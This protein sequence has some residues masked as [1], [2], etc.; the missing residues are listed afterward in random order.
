MHSTNGLTVSFVAPNAGAGFIQE[1]DFADGTVM[2]ATNPTHTY[3]AEGTYFVR[4]ITRDI[5]MT[6]ADTVSQ[7]IVVTA[8]PSCD[9]AFT[10]NTNN[11][12]VDFTASNVQPSDNLMWDFGDGNTSTVAN[13]SHTY[14][15]AGTYTV[16]LVVQDAAFTCYDS[17]A[18]TL[19]LSAPSA[20]CDA[21]FNGPTSGTTGMSMTFTA[22]NTQPTNGFEW[23]INGMTIPGATGPSLTFSPTST[24]NLMLVVSDMGCTDTTMQTITITSPPTCD[25]AFTQNTNNLTV[26][27]TASN[28]QPSDNLMWDFGDGNTSTVVNPSH[29]YA[30]A[31]TYTVLLVVQDAAFTCYDSTAQTLTVSAPSAT[32]D[33]SF[34]SANNGLTFSA[35]PNNTPAGSTYLWDFGDGNTSTQVNP[36]HNYTAQ[37]TYTVTLIHQLGACS[38][39]STTMVGMWAPPSNCNAGITASVNGMTVSFAMINPG[40]GQSNYW[41]FGDGNSSV[42]TNPTHT[43]AAPSNYMV[44]VGVSTQ[45]P[46]PFCTDSGFYVV[47]IPPPPATCDASFNQSV[48]GDTVFVSATNLNSNNTLL[49]QFGDGNSATNA[50]ANNVYAAPGTYTVSLIVQDIGMTCYDSTAQTIVISPPSTTCDASFTVNVFGDSINATANNPQPTDEYMWFVD[51]S[52]YSFQTTA[53]FDSSSLAPG[54]YTMELIVQDSNAT[55]SDTVSQTFTIAPLLAT[56]DASFNF[57]PTNLSVDFTST[58]AGS[59]YTTSWEFGDGNTSSATSPSHTYTSAG[60]YTVQLIVQDTGMTCADTIMQAVTVSAPNI[61]AC[62]VDIVPNSINGMSIDLSYTAD[63][64]PTSFTWEMGDGMIYSSPTAT[65]TYSQIGGYLIQLVAAD[66]LCADTAYYSAF[67]TPN[68]IPNSCGASFSHTVASDGLTVIF[69]DHSYDSYT[70]PGTNPNFSALETDNQAIPFAGTSILTYTYSAAGTYQAC[71]AVYDVGTGCSD[72][73]CKQITVN[74][75]PQTQTWNINGSVSTFQ[76]GTMVTVSNATVYLVEFDNSVV[77]TLTAADSVVLSPSDSGQYVFNNL[78]GGPYYVKAALNTT[79]PN[80]NSFVPTYYGNTP[81]WIYAS[82][83]PMAQLGQTAP[84]VLIAG[85]NPGGP[86]FIG[87]SLSSGANKITNTDVELSDVAVMLF[88]VSDNSLVDFDYSN[89]NDEFAIGN[90]PYGTYRLHGEVLGLKTFNHLITL[91]P[92][93]P[94]VDDVVIRVNESISTSVDEPLTYTSLLLYPNPAQDVA[95]LQVQLERPTAL[96]L[97]AFDIQG[98]QVLSQQADYAA[99]EAIISV[100]TADLADGLYTLQVRI[101]EQVEHFKLVVQR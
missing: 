81:Q 84:V 56:C 35:A 85:N 4:L 80:F 37:G 70:N 61:G 7:W 73:L 64:T 96:S 54:T 63:F 30:T 36:A 33:A 67:M 41:D 18:Q 91:G 31:G 25:A 44:Y 93:Q 39:T 71:V 29:T 51:G 8:P 94:T 3:T 92:N 86:G 17:T 1:W 82:P 22:T 48:S 38:D 20:T 89:D 95:T 6:C 74:G 43:Y 11:L 13:P 60:T 9:A 32:C 47:H 16:S 49:W 98:R 15:T 14:A 69:T 12:M 88:D 75:T 5:G 57:V 19:T 83:V 72:T 99:G 62:D 45:S 101:G 21:S 26:D 78:V 68:P 40:P 53:S 100:N 77:N 79:D 24:F 10:Q 42:G 2:T 97:Q 23:L 87:G 65:H 52:F 34:I 27:F 90:L 59:G 58:N 55:C 50:V 66:S 28:V 76:A 46:N